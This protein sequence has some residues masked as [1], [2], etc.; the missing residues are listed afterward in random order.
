MEKQ[1]FLML[2]SFFLTKRWV[3]KKEV[4][5]S[6]RIHSIDYTPSN[7]KLLRKESLDAL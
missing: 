7:L 5:E 4:F 3:E 1:D 6:R 2:C